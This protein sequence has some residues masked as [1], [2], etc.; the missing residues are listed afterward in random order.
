L[1][2]DRRQIEQ[3]SWVNNLTFPFNLL[4]AVLLNL[5][6]VKNKLFIKKMQLFRADFLGLACDFPLTGKKTAF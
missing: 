2:T 6:V 4:S 1:R 5:Y 3:N